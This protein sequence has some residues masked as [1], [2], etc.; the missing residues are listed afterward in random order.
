VARWSRWAVAIHLGRSGLVGQAA[1]KDDGLDDPA[2]VISGKQLRW[3][4]AKS[5]HRGIDE[6]SDQ[7]VNIKAMCAK[8]LDLFKGKRRVMGLNHSWECCW[9]WLSRQNHRAAIT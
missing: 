5:A 7:P 3:L 1:F 4:R 2:L 8:G 9:K 6:A